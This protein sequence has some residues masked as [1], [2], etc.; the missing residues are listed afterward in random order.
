MKPIRLKRF[1]LAK[2]WLFAAAFLLCVAA[3]VAAADNSSSFSGEWISRSIEGAGLVNNDPGC[4]AVTWTDRKIKLE[5]IVGNPNRFRG[6]WV[7][8]FQS[9]WMGVHGEECRFPGE[10]KFV[11]THMAVL[12]WTLTGVYDPK[13]D[14]LHLNGVY[15][16]CNGNVCPQMQAAGKDFNTDLR[17][18]GDDLVDVDPTLSREDWHH[19]I[20]SASEAQRTDEVIRA[21][22]PML[23]LND[24]GDFDGLYQ[25][26]DSVTHKGLSMDQFRTN[27][28][29]V[30][31]R[32]GQV[33]SRSSMNTMYAN[34]NPLSKSPGQNAIV[35]NVVYFPGN[36][37]TIEYIIV[38]KESGE[39]KLNY[40]YLGG[41]AAGPAR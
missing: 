25:Y 30:R 9:L 4:A 32:T 38:T 21:L 7:R 10:T 15:N 33:L 12:G 1:R 40:Y 26:A 3:S 31:A 14:T 6:E 11:D 36:I 16:D 39:W 17:I 22:K 8:K 24:K 19:F 5:Q 41:G 37:R 23:D 20:S 18:M 29:A 13:S 27:S 35:M 28:K 34:Y 2:M